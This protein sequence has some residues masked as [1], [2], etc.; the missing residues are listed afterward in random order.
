MQL[1][2]LLPAGPFPVNGRV[3]KVKVSKSIDRDLEKAWVA[4]GGSKRASLPSKS[5]RRPSSSATTDGR[6]CLR[7]PF[8]VAIRLP[9]DWILALINSVDCWERLV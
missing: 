8:T 1:M 3:V 4:A 7:P 6:C 2:A 9:W 5:G